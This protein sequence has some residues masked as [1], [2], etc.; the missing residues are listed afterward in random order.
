[1]RSKNWVQ[2]LFNRRT[3]HEAKP[4][5]APAITNPLLVADLVKIFIIDFL[6]DL[7]RESVRDCCRSY[8]PV[9]FLPNR[10][11]DVSSSRA[12]LNFGPPLEGCP[13]VMAQI[14]TA[15]ARIIP[16]NSDAKQYVERAIK[17]L[18][19]DG[20]LTFE[21]DFKGN[22]TH[23]VPD[24][25]TLCKLV[26]FDRNTYD[27]DRA[28]AQEQEIY[29]NTPA[30]LQGF[31]GLRLLYVNTGTLNLTYPPLGHPVILEKVIKDVICQTLFNQYRDARTSAAPDPVD[32]P[33]TAATA[34]EGALSKAHMSK[35][36]I[37]NN[38][39]KIIK[40]HILND[41]QLSSFL[42]PKVQS[43][44]KPNFDNLVLTIITKATVDKVMYELQQDG[45]IVARDLHT[46]SEAYQLSMNNLLKLIVNDK[47]SSYPP[48]DVTYAIEYLTGCGQKHPSYAPGS[49]SGRG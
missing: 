42:S 25:D 13:D 16:Q 18:L 29:L 1:M 31:S 46:E 33:A 15:V 4:G 7:Y 23:Y 26:T 20:T 14:L 24:H 36:D 2:R 32:E 39:M 8:D 10:P 48:S 43:V 44:G 35:D 34:I 22:P 28:H 38:V 21:H 45:T 47:G 19:D 11:I 5:P 40:E 6:Y 41:G 12:R 3:N 9:H 30:F 27:I 49:A 17:S 37:L